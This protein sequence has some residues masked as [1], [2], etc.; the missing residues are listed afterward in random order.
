MPRIID[1]YSKGEYPADALSNFYPH[2]FVIDVIQCASMEGF[3]QSLKYASVKR[4]KRVCALVGK[5][6]KR[7]GKRK[8]LWRL[9]KKLHWNGKSFSRF[10]EEYQ[11]LLT[12]AYSALAQCPDFVAALAA[13]DG[14]ELC[15]SAGCRDRRHTVLTEQ[16]FIAHL[17]ALRTPKI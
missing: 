2:A 1:V 17:N 9:T 11:T 6:A 3:L 7:A 5:A 4:Q 12:R 15:H 13:A 16:E 8:L 10:G 14:A